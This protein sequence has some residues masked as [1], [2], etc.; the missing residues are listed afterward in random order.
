MNK[1]IFSKRN[2]FPAQRL[3]MKKSHGDALAGTE[4]KHALGLGKQHDAGGGGKSESAWEWSGGRVHAAWPWL[5]R[6]EENIMER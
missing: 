2:S 5:I 1:T 6:G 4:I 3:Y